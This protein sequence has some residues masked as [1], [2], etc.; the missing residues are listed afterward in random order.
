MLSS[1]WLSH[2]TLSA[3]SMQWLGVVEK[4]L[5]SSLVSPQ[6]RSQGLSS[7][8]P[9][10]VGRLP[11]TKEG[12]EERPWERGWFHRSLKNNNRV[13]N[14]IPEMTKGIYSF[15][16]LWKKLKSADQMEVSVHTNILKS[17]LKEFSVRILLKLRFL[18]GDTVDSAFGLGSYQ[19]GEISSS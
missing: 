17:C 1:D 16:R 2:C 8:P 6:P 11:T 9:L 12:R 10:V 7:L 5:R 19:P 13:H 14:Q 4:K 3:I 15:F 18:R